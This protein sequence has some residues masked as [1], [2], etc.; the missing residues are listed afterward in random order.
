MYCHRQP[1]PLHHRRRK[2]PA[3]HPS[4]R[5]HSRNEADRHLTD[6]PSVLDERNTHIGHTAIVKCPTG[7]AASTLILFA[8]HN[9]QYYYYIIGECTTAHSP[10]P[11]S[12]RKSQT[13]RDY[14]RATLYSNILKYNI[15]QQ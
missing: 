7:F 13:Q 5:H 9:V 2:A 12:T 15:I 8:T 11:N 1:S 14:I 4:L 10:S 3:K 6:Q